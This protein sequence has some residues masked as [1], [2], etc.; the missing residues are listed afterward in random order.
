MIKRIIPNP[1]KNKLR[2]I[3]EKY[4]FNQIPSIDINTDRIAKMTKKDIYN[5]LNSKSFESDYNKINDLII[6]FKLPENSGGINLGDQKAIYFLTRS[7]GVKNILEIGTHIG[8]STVHY[9]LALK[10]IKLKN[11]NLD[12][13][14]IIDINDQRKKHW[15]KYGA[16]Y[17]PKNMIEL[18]GVGDFVNFFNN[19]SIDYL[20]NCNKKYDLI[21][22][23]G[24]HLASIVYQEIPL[25]LK[26]LNPN[27]IIMLHD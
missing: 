20:K 4:D 15:L 25:A 17:S 8:C 5:F 12:T 18:I 7:F 19:K 10:K 13:V 26:L 11:K 14:D 1:I 3:K 24:S 16:K 21:F 6:K 23:D 2:G 9:A 22:L 27:G